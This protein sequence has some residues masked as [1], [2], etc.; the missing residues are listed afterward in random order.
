MGFERITPENLEVYRDLIPEDVAENIG[1]PCYRGISL[2]GD[3]PDTALIW[4]LQDADEDREETSSEIVWLCAPGTEEGRELFRAYREAAEEERGTQTFFELPGD[5]LPAGLL[6]DEGFSPEQKEG[7]DV[8]VSVGELGELLLAKG[9]V[10]S[11]ILN[12]GE[13]MVRQYRRGIMDALFH[14]KKG[15]M[16]DLAYLPMDFFEPDISS[17]LMTDGKISGFLLVHV[18]PSGKLLLSLL[19]GFGPDTRVD[20]A[21]MIRRSIQAAVQKYPADTRVILRRHNDASMRLASMFF[22]DKKGE[23]VTT[24][25]RR[26]D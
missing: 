14:Q 5:D 9:R 4:E 10:P 21:M 19:C 3:E 16:E 1:R 17:A 15:I 13:L 25:T 23:T 7:R 20:L 22:P 24:G 18:L 12:L 26:E 11:Y 6:A 2:G 8:T